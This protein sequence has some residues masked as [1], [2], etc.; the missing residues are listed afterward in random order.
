[1]HDRLF[2][3]QRELS[4]DAYERFAKEI[5]L[6]VRRF[7]ESLRSGRA[8]PRIEED[9]RLAARI[10]AQA[11]PTMFVNGERVEGAVPFATLKAVIDRK[12][13]L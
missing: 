12:L 11:T 3:S 8:K 9:Q 5:G 2:A 13:G 7:Q 4:P 1:M 10:G 6:D